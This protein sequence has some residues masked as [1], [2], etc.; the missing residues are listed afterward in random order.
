MLKV[1]SGI[2]GVME[3]LV[4]FRVDPRGEQWPMSPMGTLSNALASHVV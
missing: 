1:F 3:A 2:L 4:V